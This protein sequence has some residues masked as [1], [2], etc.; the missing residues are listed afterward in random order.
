MFDV[1][2][3]A[4]KAPKR[5]KH[6]RR[7]VL[8]IV[9]AVL[10]VTI[11][12]GYVYVEPMYTEFKSQVSLDKLDQ[13]LDVSTRVID[14][15]G[16]LIGNIGVEHR[17]ELAYEDFPKDLVNAQIA[18]ED[19][20]FWTHPGVSVRG[21]T[22][23]A[24]RG[25]KNGFRFRQGG[26]TIDQQVIKNYLGCMNET[27]GGSKERSKSTVGGKAKPKRDLSCKIVE[28]MAAFELDRNYSKKQI[29]TMY[30]N[31]VCFD[32]NH[33][34]MESAARMYFG[35][36]VKEL[37]LAQLA[38]LAGLVQD[39]IG[40]SPY[41]H[42]ERAKARQMYVLGRMKELKMISSKTYREAAEEELVYSPER[43]PEA[44]SGQNVL[45]K[46][47]KDL[48]EMFGTIENV[49]KL[50]LT[51][52]LTIDIDLQNYAEQ[53]LVA[54]TKAVMARQGGKAPQGAIVVMDKETG[55]ILALVGG[56]PYVPGGFN[57]AFTQRHAGS[58]YKPFVYAA[59]LEKGL[60][61]STVYADQKICYLNEGQPIWCPGNYDGEKAPGGSASALDAIAHSYNTVAV[62]VMCGVD[63]Q[64]TV[65]GDPELQPL[66]DIGWKQCKANGVV[67][68]T[69]D[70]SRKV[71]I[72]SKLNALPSLAL[73]TSE[74]TP[75]EMTGAYAVF[76]NNGEYI[77]P[78][79]IK[80]I[81]GKKA[82]KIPEREK[83]VVMPESVAVSMN[84]A[85][86]SVATSGTARSAEGKLP[87][88]VFGKTG[89]TADFSDTWF[90]GY[91]GNLVATVWVGHNNPAVN[92][93]GRGETGARTSLPIWVKVMNRALTGRVSAGGYDTR[94]RATAGDDAFPPPPSFEDTA[95]ETPSPAPQYEQQIPTDEPSAASEGSG[96]DVTGI[97]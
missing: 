66:T 92:K 35:K 30:F 79:L 24:L 42:P 67:N 28:A 75:V 1:D 70:L 87:F 95:V 21:I 45:D 68:Q 11:I 73:G 65:T 50:G 13:Q 9:A 74:V 77:E 94:Y 41:R 39:P 63:P 12:A 60:S 14:R 49:S 85:L 18:A 44:R 20:D 88:P 27:R 62:K 7:T 90:V 31:K 80:S 38:V 53:E 3:G 86:R 2:I 64:F 47:R 93:L 17:I 57:Y 76:A 97:Q 91:A 33:C 36:G 58:T 69:I 26:S 59:A 83:R 25:I 72:T 84:T 23:A 55:E 19:Q 32:H 46:V 29:L 22:R 56:A 82:P 43:P 61:L 5:A 37:S 48:V 71:G 52:Q 8:K 89:T 40:K 10:V 51:V 15:N 16:K 6:W 81:T 78:A 54:G 96:T 4:E 34:G